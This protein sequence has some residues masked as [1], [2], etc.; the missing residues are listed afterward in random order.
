[1]T[2]AIADRLWEEISP[3]AD[4]AERSVWDS[5]S[6]EDRKSFLRKFWQLRAGISAVDVSERLAEHYRRLA[7]VLDQYVRISGGPQ[8]SSA[9]L[10]R[11]RDSAPFDERGLIYIRH[12]KP[13]TVVSTSQDRSARHAACGRDGAYT[14]NESWLYHRLGERPHFVNFLRCAGFPDWIIPYRIP[15]DRFYMMDR[16]AFDDDI[17][18]CDQFT[19]ER[20]RDFALELVRSDTHAPRFEAPVPFAYD[21]LAFRGANGKTDLSAPVAA[22]AG[23]LRPD[24][25]PTGELAYRLSLS[26]FV[27]DTIAGTVTRADTILVYRAARAPDPTDAIVGYINLTAAP[28]ADA[29]HRVV[30]RDAGQPE[31]GQLHGAHISVPSYG[32]ASLMLS[33]VVIAIP[34]SGGNWRRGATSLTITPLAELTGGAFRIFYEIYNLLANTPYST[35]IAIER[36]AVSQPVVQ[37]RF[38]DQA[39]PDADGTIQELRSIDTRLAPGRYRLHLRVTNLVTGEDARQQRLFSVIR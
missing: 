27:V 3:A 12:G 26:M 25:L 19:L 4:S 32:V 36:E 15:C 16:M 33:S 14:A 7:Y 38:E 18:F 21:L 39:Q 37:V 6:L 30:L 28:T 31:N 8:P 22:E 29:L 1:M 11:D 5:S 9:T 2:P 17:N 13:D 20:T 35:E 24:T 23:S 34:G 10:L